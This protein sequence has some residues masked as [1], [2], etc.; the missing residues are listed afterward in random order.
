MNIDNSIE[1][2]KIEGQIEVISALY[3]TGLITPEECESRLGTAVGQF[4]ALY[5]AGAVDSKFNYDLAVSISS[6]VEELNLKC[7]ESRPDGEIFWTMRHVAKPGELLPDV[8]DTLAR[9]MKIKDDARLNEIRKDKEL[10]VVAEG[11]HMCVDDN[12]YSTYNAE[13]EFEIGEGANTIQEA[14][15]IVEKF[16]KETVETNQNYCDGHD[17]L[18]GYYS[19]RLFTVYSPMGDPLFAGFWQ[20]DKQAYIVPEPLTDAA[21][22]ELHE[23]KVRL[24]EALSENQRADNY[25]TCRQIR[26]ELVK[27]ELKLVTSDFWTT[28][29]DYPGDAVIGDFTESVKKFNAQFV[30]VTEL[31]SSPEVHSSNIKELFQPITALNE[32]TPASGTTLLEEEIMEADLGIHERAHNRAR[33]N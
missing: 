9:S 12:G 25:D 23:E 1:L 30:S 6:A 31:S 15:D 5:D 7:L 33:I 14:L 16:Q 28:V 17:L 20:Y 18:P 3:D 29:N 2:A 10:R 8:D 26:D 11:W 19:P 27:I 32:D 24:N 13:I 21:Y 4:V 22:N